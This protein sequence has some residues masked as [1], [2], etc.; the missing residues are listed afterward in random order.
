MISR[1]NFFSMTLMMAALFF[2][3]Q[4]SQIM[5]EQENDYHTNEYVGGIDI[6]MGDYWQ[7][8]EM[9]FASGDFVVFVGR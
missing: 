9:H 8:G 5:K 4:F 3:F 7:S 2:L 6:E 1:R